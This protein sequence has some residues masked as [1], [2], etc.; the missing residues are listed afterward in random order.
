[1]RVESARA[2]AHDVDH[3]AQMGFV[4]SGMPGPG[5]G[6]SSGGVDPALRG[7]NVFSIRFLDGAHG[8]QVFIEFPPRRWR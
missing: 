2:P 5:R 3:Q 4:V 7:F 8:F 6:R 1:M